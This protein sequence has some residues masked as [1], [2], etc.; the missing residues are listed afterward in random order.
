MKF[1]YNGKLIRTSKN[2]QYT[3][4]VIYEPT[5]ECIGCRTSYEACLSFLNGEINGARQQVENAQRKIDAINNGRTHYIY[6]DGR[7][8][9]RYPIT[10]TGAYKMSAEEWLECA[11]QYLD[12]VQNAWKIVELEMR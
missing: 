9:F 1:Y 3:H 4:A 10:E 5:N 11:K 2:H 6:K 8:E 12:K 7:K